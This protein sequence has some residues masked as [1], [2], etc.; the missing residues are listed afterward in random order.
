MDIKSKSLADQIEKNVDEQTERINTEKR[1]VLRVGLALILF[2]F[3]YFSYLGHVIRKE[4]K[5]DEVAK[6]ISA[7][8]TELVSNIS[9]EYGE[10]LL[11]IAP[12]YV[13]E[14]FDTGFL[15]IMS[16][17]PE[18]KSIV[19][20]WIE[21]RFDATEA[22]L[23]NLFDYAYAEHVQDLKHL[24]QNIDLPQG[25]QN[26]EEFL[27]NLISSSISPVAHQND[28]EGM[29]QTLIT[30]HEKIN[31]LASGT[32]LSPEEKNERELMFSFREFWDRLSKNSEK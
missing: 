20:N 15:H 30:I 19:I 5:P 32:D 24:I 29:L 4:V 22:L 7:N 16:I 3:I 1:R 17:R 18:G 13:K 14:L 26:F 25:K 9:K 11:R 27:T 23:D 31:R 12:Q 2:I 8:L 21:E 28:L 6:I 10:N